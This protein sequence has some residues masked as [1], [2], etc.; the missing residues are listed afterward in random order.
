MVIKAHKH[1]V[2]KFSELL[3]WL[4]ISNP[5]EFDQSLGH[6]F[7]EYKL[8]NF[9]MSFSGVMPRFDYKLQANH[10]LE[11]AALILSNVTFTANN[12]ELLITIE[13]K[14]DFD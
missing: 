7:Y 12:S 13:I 4:E 14:I 9:L 6:N 5:L 2:S 1:G 8:K 3:Y 10:L 11:N